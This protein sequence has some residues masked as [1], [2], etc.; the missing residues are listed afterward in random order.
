VKSGGRGYEGSGSLSTSALICREIPSLVM[1][2]AEGGWTA[3]GS[4]HV[5]SQTVIDSCTGISVA[6]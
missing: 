6:L 1:Q 2:D 3:E 5:I 4:F